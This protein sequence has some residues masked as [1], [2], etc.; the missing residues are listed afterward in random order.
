M[1]KT[2]I[3]ID[4]LLAAIIGPIPNVTE[5]MIQEA[6]EGKIKYVVLDHALY[7]ALYSVRDGDKINAKRLADLLQ[8]AELQN[9]RLLGIK[10]YKTLPPSEEEIE[11]WRKVV[12]G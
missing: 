2:M 8:Y 5:Q 6:R 7:C 3:A 1:K 11:H 9:S 4:L 12:L 10:K